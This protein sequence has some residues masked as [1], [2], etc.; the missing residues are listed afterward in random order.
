MGSTGERAGRKRRQPGDSASPEPSP[1]ALKDAAEE[2]GGGVQGAA[3][4][5]EAD[6]AERGRKRNKGSEMGGTGSANEDA[7]SSLANEGGQKPAAADGVS[8]C[9]A[10]S[11]GSE[12]P[13]QEG[14][15]ES[16]AAKGEQ[17]NE[18]VSMDDADDDGAGGVV[19][20]DDDME[21]SEDGRKDD[22]YK[23]M[24][25]GA[26]P[27]APQAQCGKEW[28]VKEVRIPR[29]IPPASRC[30]LNSRD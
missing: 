27:V 28:E 19:E 23:D 2:A 26:V 29:A 4:G 11:P 1:G 12:A 22:G 15:D 9:G 13:G 24:G 8:G 17:H 5:G 7:P 30:A 20:E 18:D 16:P 21:D 6:D 3:C 14:T 10:A 25:I